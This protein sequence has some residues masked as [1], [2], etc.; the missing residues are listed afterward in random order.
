MLW[1]PKSLLSFQLLLVNLRMMPVLP[2]PLFSMA[3]SSCYLTLMG[4]MLELLKNNLVS[5][6]ILGFFF[7]VYYLILSLSSKKAV[8]DWDANCHLRLWAPGTRH[9]GRLACPVGR[10]RLHLWWANFPDTRLCQRRWDYTRL[11]R[12]TTVCKRLGLF[13][14]LY[15]TAQRSW[16]TTMERERHNGYRTKRPFNLYWTNMEP[17]QTGVGL[18]PSA[19]KCCLSRVFIFPQ[20]SLTTLD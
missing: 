15:P 8:Q 3:N 6:N 2:F 19:P 18:L 16:K 9:L 7:P 10:A 12:V 13:P 14:F 4:I 20:A 1:P 11:A 5:Q 17:V